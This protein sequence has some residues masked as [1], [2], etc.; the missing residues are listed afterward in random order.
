MQEC[1][2]DSVHSVPLQLHGETAT[3]RMISPM[4]AS[5]PLNSVVAVLQVLNDNSC[6]PSIML[7]DYAVHYKGPPNRNAATQNNSL[8]F[9]V[10]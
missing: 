4:S 9:H 5:F 2:G 10:F 1:R 6:V 7:Q 3:A 8:K